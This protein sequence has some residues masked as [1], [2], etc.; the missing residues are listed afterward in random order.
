[1][2]AAQGPHSQILMMGGGGVR[3]RFIFYTQKNHN[4]RICLPQKITTF[5]AY[6]RKSHSPSFVTPKNPSVFLC[7]PQ[8]PGVFHRPKKITFGQNF[9]PKKITQNP[10]PTLKYVSGIPGG[11]SIVYN[12]IMVIFSSEICKVTI[13]AAEIL[14]EIS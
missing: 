5:L 4:F 3:Q 8:N 12:F 11:C 7:N 2:V 1:M 9:R 13:F 14:E 10:P 6:P